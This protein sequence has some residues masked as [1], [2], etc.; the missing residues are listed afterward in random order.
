MKR[1][2]VFVIVC[3]FW[4]CKLVEVEILKPQYNVYCILNPDDKK[5]ELFLGN[6]YNLVNPSKLILVNIFQKLRY[7]SLIKRILCN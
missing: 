7:L 2:L 4:S 6:V 1:L 5:I 3:T